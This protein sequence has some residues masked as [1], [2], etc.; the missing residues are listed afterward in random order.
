MRI[1]RTEIPLSF[2]G[3]IA[4]G[5][6]TIVISCI[7]FLRTE[8]WVRIIALAV[9]VFIFFSYR[10]FLAKRKMSPVLE[11]ALKDEDSHKKYG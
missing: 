7:L 5:I 2:I 3:K 1:G 10:Q 11:K 9:L 8:G 4:A 6:A